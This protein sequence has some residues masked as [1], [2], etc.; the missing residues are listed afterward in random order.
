MNIT[1]KPIAPLFFFI[2]ASALFS[3]SG[4]HQST[5]TQS[6]DLDLSQITV[7]G[8]QGPGDFLGNID[9]SDW[10]SSSYD[11]ILFR[12][13]FWI[14]KASLS[15]SLS[16][17]GRAAGDTSSQELRIYNRSNKNLSVT[18]QLQGSF[19]ADQD[20]LQILPASLGRIN[21]SFVLP[22]T[23]TTVHNG[24]L[25]LHFSTGDSIQLILQGARTR[26]VDSAVSVGM[27]VHFALAPAYPNPTDGEIRFEF[28]LPRATNAVLRVVNKKNELVTVIAQGNYMAGVHQVSW[29]VNLANGNYRVVFDAGTYVST[30]DIQ[31]SR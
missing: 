10:D 2:I 9:V 4:C 12:K 8:T 5:D 22:D 18:P 1:H 31:V 28:S 27:P 29:N 7:T 25:T 14:Q 17:G 23:T 15:D 24:V 26:S 11:Q 16:F 21:I 6:Q 30:G 13:P 3:I 20:S 19:F